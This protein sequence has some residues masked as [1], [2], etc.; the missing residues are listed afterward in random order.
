MIW[1]K[2]ITSIKHTVFFPESLAKAAHVS[3]VCFLKETRKRRGNPSSYFIDVLSV[4]SARSLF[5]PEAFK[6]RHFLY[7]MNSLC[8]GRSQQ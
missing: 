6:A 8:M 4:K 1:N 2:H 5:Y 7:G 3:V